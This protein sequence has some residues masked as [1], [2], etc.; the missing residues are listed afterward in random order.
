MLE[1]ARRKSVARDALGKLLERQQRD[2]QQTLDL[3]TS[4]ESVEGDVFERED[5]R[6]RRRHREGE[7]IDDAS[8]SSSSSSFDDDDDD[9]DEYDDA[10][11]SSSIMS[12]IVASVAS[13][14]DYG[15]TSRSEGCRSES[16]KS[17]NY[18]GGG[19]GG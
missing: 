15:Y 13:G 7:D 16:I 4:L 3:L 8:S 1:A 14:V 19:S 9:D 11:T 6:L 12:S 5:R 18:L 10:I 17:G 2:M